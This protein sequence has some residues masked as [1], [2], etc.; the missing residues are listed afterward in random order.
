MGAGPGLPPRSLQTL[1]QGAHA[2]LP[3]HLRGLIKRGL[4]VTVVF[5]LP[6]AQWTAARARPEG[7]CA[8]FRPL[9]QPF[10]ISCS[11]VGNITGKI[12]R[13]WRIGFSSLSREHP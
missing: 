3:D 13:Q 12:W 10:T 11:S 9:A 2:V 8:V 5:G 7:I 6:P 4:V 1:R